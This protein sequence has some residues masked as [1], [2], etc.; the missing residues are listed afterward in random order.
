MI[1]PNG[2]AVPQTK[3]FVSSQTLTQFNDKINRLAAGE[4]V[5]DENLF[6]LLR[7]HFQEWKDELEN[8]QKTCE[9]YEQ[10]IIS[11]SDSL[12]CS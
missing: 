10:K 5:N 2:I 6:V 12:E 9:R 11:T 8:S 4:V 7:I 3:G 1:I